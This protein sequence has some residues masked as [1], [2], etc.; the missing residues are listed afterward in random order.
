MEDVKNIM[1]RISDAKE[2]AAEKIS[3]DES[4]A[5]YQQSI[6]SLS[7]LA[8][9]LSS[10]VDANEIEAASVSMDGL[11]THSIEGL[12]KKYSNMLSDITYRY[13]EHFGLIDPDLK[14][15]LDG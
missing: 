11:N 8:V 5:L 1:D 4:V 7:R 9:C 13:D 12:D 14:D 2:Y 10:K 6:D 3:S 15:L